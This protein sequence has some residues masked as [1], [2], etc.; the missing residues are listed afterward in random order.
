M[1]NCDCGGSALV[2]GSRLRA[3]HTRS[4]GCLKRNRLGDATRKHGLSKTPQYTMFYD[5]RKRSIALSLPFSI[6]PDDVIVPAT[7]PV[8]GIPINVNGGRDNQP[9]L[10]RI[11]P[12][13]GYVR[14]NV[15]VISFR[16]NQIKSDASPDELQRILA[17]MEAAC[18][19]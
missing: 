7:C 1:C 17:Y 11:V 4:C 9:S 3:G 13:A 2:P 19:I 6:T 16:A 18:A 10:D 5:A 14:G 15:A 12:K 8:L